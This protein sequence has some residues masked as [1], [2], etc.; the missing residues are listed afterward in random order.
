M[1]SPD[2]RARARQ[3]N[4]KA[5]ATKGDWLLMLSSCIWLEGATAAEHSDDGE[6]GDRS[7]I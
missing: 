1:K 2:K 3:R 6:E 4:K 5:A 7:N